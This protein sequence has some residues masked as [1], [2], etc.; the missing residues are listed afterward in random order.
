MVEFVIGRP[1]QS[2]RSFF[3]GQ[4]YIEYFFDQCLFPSAADIFS[5]LQFVVN[6]FPSFFK[7]FLSTLQY[8]HWIGTIGQK[9]QL[10]LQSKNITLRLRCRFGTSSSATAATCWNSRLNLY[11]VIDPFDGN[12]QSYTENQEGHQA[13]D[14]L[15]VVRPDIV[16]QAVGVYIEKV[17][18]DAYPNYR[19]Q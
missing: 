11:Q 16:Y 5:W 2:R 3:C 14:N 8:L 10:P 15:L 7:R 17:Y 9:C 19:Y 6:S 4:H 1:S 12:L 13:V 18:Q